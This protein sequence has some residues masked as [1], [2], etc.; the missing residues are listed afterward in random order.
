MSER[1]VV[2]ITGS[3]RG[4]GAA[5]ARLFASKNY[6]VVVNYNNSIEETEK[7][8]NELGKFN[9][10]VLCIKGDVTNE[11]DVTRMVNA[12]NE[13]FGKID[14]LVNNAGISIDND[15]DD[16]ELVEF[17][18]VIDTNLTSVFLVTKYASKLMKNG[19][20]INVTSTDGIDTCYKEEMDYAAAKAGVIN[21]TKN[22]AK[23]F[24]PNIRVNAVAPGWINTDM[25]KDLEESFKNCEV[26][27]I[28]LK[29]FGEP[30][31]IA[32]VIYFLA[33]EEASY[34]NGTIIR[35]DGG[36]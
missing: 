31:E 10:N 1:K 6:D 28:L 20:I 9:I 29:R 27:K 32:N 2:F 14:V 7:L 19:S 33:S 12:I 13:K 22:M 36:Y 11:E 18:K 3:S 21:L 8:E 4:L 30:S 24:S 34:I 5:T 26:E 25:T 16:K 23:K 35:V 17:R 15:I